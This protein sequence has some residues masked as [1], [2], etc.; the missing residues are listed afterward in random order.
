MHCI[1]F[2]HMQ[3]ATFPTHFITLDLIILMFDV[4]Q[5]S[6][7]S[8]YF[9]PLRS[10]YSPQH[11]IPKYPWTTFWPQHEILKFHTQIRNR[12]NFTL[13]ILDSIRLDVSGRI[14]VQTEN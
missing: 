4:M 13:Y 9:L 11:P 6:V 12:Q 2:P 10:Q 8:S 14:L 3:H 7:G 5:V 1:S